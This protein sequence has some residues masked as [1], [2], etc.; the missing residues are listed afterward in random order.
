MNRYLNLNLGDQLTPL[1]ENLGSD[2]PAA[3]QSVLRT[4]WNRTTA[5]SGCPIGPLGDWASELLETALNAAQHG[6]NPL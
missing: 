4:K 6:R 3:F 1:L 5:Q 2:I